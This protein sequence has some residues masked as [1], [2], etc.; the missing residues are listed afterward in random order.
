MD[1]ILLL[2]LG[3]VILAIVQTLAFVLAVMI[4]SVLIVVSTATS[5]V[6][7]KKP[8]ST[9]CGKPRGQRGRYEW[10]HTISTAGYAAMAVAITYGIKIVELLSN[11]QTIDTG[12]ASDTI[13][14]TLAVIIAGCVKL[15]VQTRKDNTDKKT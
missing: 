12:W 3:I 4:V 15:W 8:K 2:C 9:V 10:T 13:A 11:Q 6:S 7:H 14:G 1:P 5:M